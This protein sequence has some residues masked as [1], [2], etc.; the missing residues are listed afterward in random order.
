MPVQDA[1]KFRFVSPGIF[2]NEIDQSRIPAEPTN[3]GPV[4]IG[5]SRQGPG[6]IPVTVNS[7]S[8]FVDVF[9]EPVSGRSGVDD[10]WRQ[11]NFSSPTYAAYA[12]QAYLAAGVG[13]V[14]FIRLMGTQHPQAVDASG[15]NEGRAGY[16]TA[17]VPTSSIGTNGGPYGL[18]VFASGTV[19]DEHANAGGITNAGSLA[20]VWYMDHGVPVLSGTCVRTRDALPGQPVEGTAVV[21]KSDSSGQFKV[22]ILDSSSAEIENVT[23]SLNSS[24]PNFIRRVFNTNPQLCNGSHRSN[25]EHAGNT[26]NYWLGETFERYLKEQELDTA[27]E[28]FG[29]ILALVSG[30]TDVYGNH[31]RDTGYRDA[32]TGWF[33]AQNFNAA[34]SAFEY[35]NQK[36]LFKFVGINGYGEW[37]QNNIKIAIDNIKVAPNNNIK[38]GT[39]DVVIRRADDSDLTQVVLERYSNCTLDPSSPDYIAAKIGDTKRFYDEVEK[40]YRT[41]GNYPNMSK[42]VRVVMD[43]VIDLGGVAEPYLPFGVFGPPRFPAFRFHHSS[44]TDSGALP[45]DAYVLGSSSIPFGFG[46]NYGATIAGPGYVNGDGP[47]RFVSAG[48]GNG[49]FAHAF[50]TASITYP[51]VGIRVSASDDGANERSAY[52]GLIT[53][54]ATNATKKSTVF[55][56]GYSDHLKMF[57]YNIVSD[58]QWADDFGNANTNNG[59]PLGVGTTASLDRQWVFTLDEVR[60]NKATGFSNSTPARNISSVYWQSGSM[61]AGVSWNASNSIGDGAARFENVLES[62]INRFISPMWGAHDGLDITERDPFRNSRLDDNSEVEEQNYAFYTIKR[63]IDQISDKDSLELNIATIPGITNE[64]LTK[65]LIDACEDRGDAL[66]IIDVKGGFKPRADDVSTQ[67]KAIDRKGDVLTVVN[68]MKNRNLNNSYGAAYYPFVKIRDDL[69]GGIIVDV[70]PSVV[71]LGVLANTERA[72]DVWFAPAGFRRGGLSAGAGGLPVIGVEEKLTAKNRDDLYEVNINPIASFPAEGIVIFG[73][74]T[75][76]ANRSAL[77]RI[78]VRRLLIFVKRGISLIAS[79][80]LFQ[81]N[82][83]TTWNSFKTRADNFLTDVRVRFGVDDFKVVLDETTTTP[84]LVDRNILYAKIFIKPTRAVEFIAIDFII[85]RSG[86]SFED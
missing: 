64:S 19:G 62:G 8:E 66:G 30:S 79:Q 17:K 36:K 43:D 56:P 82:V 2:L 27:A 3:V 20:A 73:Q 47:D 69:N 48:A 76:Q 83:T 18:F 80:T 33:F 46:A 84:D 11:G 71:A 13:P 37:L 85:T 58:G 22:R 63:A 39:F 15:V 45:G 51:S 28:R 54:K 35:K 44:S 67:K 40:R 78:N 42:Y 21:V 9:G 31:E 12:A 86:A 29:V 1:R 59:L 34:T 77:D 57:G 14:T 24:S 52:F 75:L 41:H 49:L 72:A 55:D 61:K 5:R 26:K 10:V 53:G 70:P 81:P 65:A 16:T 38:M 32:H 23:F 25:I 6:L 60:I 50:G 7:F 74:K 68:N 4:I